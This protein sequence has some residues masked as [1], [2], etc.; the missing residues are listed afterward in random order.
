[1]PCQGVCVSTC[2]LPFDTAHG[3]SNGARVRGSFLPSGQQRGDPD[4]A[5]TGKSYLY[6]GGGVD[7]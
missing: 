6:Q 3:Y 1:M 7:V 5:N 4:S 2:A